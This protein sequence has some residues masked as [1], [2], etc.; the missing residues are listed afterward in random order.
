[1]VKGL[2]LLLAALAALSNPRPLPAA[3]G[4]SCW[5]RDLSSPA[6]SL[7]YAMCAQGTLWTTTDSGATWTSRDMGTDK[8]LRA[9]A[10]LDANR[11]ISVGDGGLILGTE[12]GGKT[13]KPRPSG[14]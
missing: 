11:G 2:F 3:E 1:M 7:A 5:L 10:F 9:L 14:V 4:R 6:N 12:D 13:W 8:A